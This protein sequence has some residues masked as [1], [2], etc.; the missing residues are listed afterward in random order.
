MNAANEFMI[1]YCINDSKEFKIKIYKKPEVKK[2]MIIR[3]FNKQLEFSTFLD[4]EQILLKTDKKFMVFSNDA[5][6]INT[7]RFYNQDKQT[8]IKLPEINGEEKWQDHMTFRD[9]NPIDPNLF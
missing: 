6:F 9:E 8:L 3:D 5:E 1:I 2:Q 4:D 7:I